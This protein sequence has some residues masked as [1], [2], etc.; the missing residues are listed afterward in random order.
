MMMTSTPSGIFVRLYLSFAIPRFRFLRN[1]G[2]GA[3]R[4]QTHIAMNPTARM[5]AARNGKEGR[6]KIVTTA[7]AVVRGGGLTEEDMDASGLERL[8]S[9][10]TLALNPFL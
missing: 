8:Y 9:L 7:A 4:R 2:R 10:K 5:K 6:R 3:G 1:G